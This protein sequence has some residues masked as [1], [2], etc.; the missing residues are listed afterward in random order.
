MLG[1]VRR[2]VFRNRGRRKGRKGGKGGQGGRDVGGR[3]T[4]GGKCGT[5]ILRQNKS[6]KYKNVTQQ[7]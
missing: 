5:V 6:R 3:S 4:Q 2:R 1:G 7:I